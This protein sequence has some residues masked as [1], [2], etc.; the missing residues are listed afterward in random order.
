MLSLPKR[1]FTAANRRCIVVAAWVFVVTPAYAQSE[2]EA[3]PLTA[4]LTLGFDSSLPA[5]RT[6]TWTPLSALLENGGDPIQGRL[7]AQIY[8]GQ[9]STDIFYSC[10]VDLPTGS[11]KMYR[12][13][14]FLS[15]ETAEVQ[16]VLE[17]GRKQVALGHLATA[18][19]DDQF[20]IVGALT[21][22]RDSLNFMGT[23]PEEAEEEQTIRRILYVDAQ[24]LPTEWIAYQGLDS[25][26]WAGGQAET[27]LLPEQL[28]AF[29]SWLTMGGRL[30]LF[31]GSLRQELTETPWAQFL[32]LELTGS[33]TL[34]AGTVLEGSFF[35]DP[36]TLSRPVVVSTGTLHEALKP[37]V[38]LRAGEIPVVVEVDWGAGTVIYC[39]LAPQLVLLTSPAATLHLWDVLLTG[40]GNLPASVTIQFDPVVE[41]FLRSLVQAELPSAWFIAGFLGLY[42]LLIVPVNYFVFRRFRRLEWA[43]L[44]VPVWAIVFT[45]GAYHIGAIHQQGT[46]NLNALS[47]IETFPNSTRGRATSF[48]SIYSPVRSWYNVRFAGGVFPHLITGGAFFGPSLPTSS[49]QTLLVHYDPDTTVIADVLI[50][51]WSQRMVKAAHAIDLG[52]GVAID[53]SWDDDRLVGTVTNRTTYT[54]HDPILYILDRSYRLGDRLEPRQ[55]RSVPEV[56]QQFD[57]RKAE[58][59]LGE[60]GLLA[61]YLVRRSRRLSTWGTQQIEQFALLYR[62]WLYTDPFG[63]NLSLL[64]G[65]IDHL[66]LEPELD[67]SVSRQKGQAVLA[68]LFSPYSWPTGVIRI[69]PTSWHTQSLFV[70]G[71]PGVSRRMGDFLRVQPG[72]SEEFTLVTDLPLRGSQIRR[73]RILPKPA[74]AQQLYGSSGREAIIYVQNQQAKKWKEIPWKMSEVRQTMMIIGSEDVADPHL[75]VKMR[76]GTIAIRIENPGLGVV[77]VP[78]DPLTVTLE[79]EY[80]GSADDQRGL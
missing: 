26:I 57:R 2:N 16:V 28:S 19:L 10:P 20:E 37:R 6:D 58:E 73:L 15:G 68:V 40:L 72:K 38:L 53:L 8:Y 66:F 67:R 22:E 76:T 4:T 51:H 42:I 61:P 47:V 43:W 63:R 12:I 69:P 41:R 54:I 18:A 33:Q 29:R 46:V 3:L 70:Q 39:A 50:H 32:P 13:P 65:W 48:I 31:A 23:R 75:Y 21:R 35:R 56:S 34:P 79:V 55:S 78:A 36:Q 25:L 77:R 17:Y 9:E 71:W 24:T 49:D 27:A 74:F 80:R 45:V 5:R 11:R 14:V 30:V 1:L 52:E 7:V 44:M 59:E 60:R 62:C 64:T